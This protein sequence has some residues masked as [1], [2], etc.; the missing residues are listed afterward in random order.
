MKTGKSQA[1][2]KITPFLWLNNR[3][4]EAARFYVSIFKR[5]EILG[6]GPMSATVRLNGQKL[7]LFNGGPHYKLT[8]A[9]SLFIHCRTQREVDYYWTRLSRDGK[10]SRCGWVEDKFGLSWQVVPDILSALLS[11][12]DPVKAGRAMQ[13]MLKMRKLDIRALQRAHA[14]R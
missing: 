3:A 13:A 6:T 5:A 7:I 8:P 1:S 12:K 14:G 2:S 11:D 10:Q 4:A 9:C